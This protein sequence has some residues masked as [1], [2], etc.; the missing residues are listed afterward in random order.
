MLATGVV[1]HITFAVAYGYKVSSTT[2]TE[3]H[4]LIN[5]SLLLKPK[6]SNQQ[7]WLLF[8]V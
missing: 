6:T 5:V 2:V 3:N 1:Q 8:S 4:C 7:T